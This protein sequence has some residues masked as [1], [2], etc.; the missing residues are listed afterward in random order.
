[1]NGYRRIACFTILSAAIV[2]FAACNIGGSREPIITRENDSSAAKDES[3]V[4]NIKRVG[5]VNDYANVLNRD[6][7]DRLEKKL[8]ELKEESDVE[9]VIVLVDSLEGQT[10]ENYSANLARLW[11]LDP[12]KESDKKIL[13]V[14][15]MKGQEFRT[16]VTKGLW[17]KLP[18]EILSEF[19]KNITKE[20]SD[21]QYET[22]LTLY[23]DAI[24]KR[25]DD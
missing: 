9:F 12:Q 13:L 8:S 18:N 14:I 3:A 4:V 6:A 16:N 20:F 15:D 1:M 5:Y 10:L 2:F 21:E 17:D 23:I 25:L 22:G 19:E 24:E 7:R 11:C